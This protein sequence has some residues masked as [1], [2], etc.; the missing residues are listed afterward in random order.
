MEKCDRN[1]QAPK[2]LLCKNL[3]YSII[4]PKGNTANK[5]CTKDALDLN[6]EI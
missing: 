3:L 1:L 2:H 6:L 4:V 5:V